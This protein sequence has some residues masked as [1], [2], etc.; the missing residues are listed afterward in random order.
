M[1]IIGAYCREVVQVV[2]RVKTTATEV[3]TRPINFFG[4]STVAATKNVVKSK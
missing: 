2:A 4:V 1:V 3:A